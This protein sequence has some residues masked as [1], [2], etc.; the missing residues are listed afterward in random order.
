MK[1]RNAAARSA[2]IVTILLLSLL[3]GYIYST[4]WHSIDLRSHPR[5][6]RELVETYAAAYGVPEDLI[7][8]VIL[9]G[10]EFRSNHVSEDGRVGLMQ[11]S[12]ATFARL[13]KITKE[14][15]DPG[16]LYDPE[17]NIRYGT[18]WLSYLYTQYGRWHT[19]LA[20]HVSDDEDLVKLW[21]ESGLYT[22]DKG[23]LTEIPVDTV[24]ETV[25]DIEKARE[26]YHELYY[27][28]P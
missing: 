2:V 3:C 9:N 24:A 4:V 6:C 20:V 5:D 17:T 13:T 16:M 15:F 22:D 23:N 8:A 11:L 26:K 28:E 25:E 12:E 14:N 21:L 27:G 7:Y 19:V 18:Y 10:S 1:F